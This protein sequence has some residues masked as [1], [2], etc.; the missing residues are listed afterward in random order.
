MLSFMTIGKLVEY[1]HNQIDTPTPLGNDTMGIFW[2]D[3][4]SLSK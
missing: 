4:S 1:D 3:T 2:S